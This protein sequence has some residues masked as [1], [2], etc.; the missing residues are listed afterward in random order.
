MQTPIS[1]I[2]ELTEMIKRKENPKD[3]DKQLSL[4]INTAHMLHN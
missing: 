1:L 2:I 3:L 4:L